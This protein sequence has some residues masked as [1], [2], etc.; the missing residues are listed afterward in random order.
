MPPADEWAALPGLLLTTDL[1]E[2]QLRTD[3]WREITRPLFETTPPV[4]QT[5]LEGSLRSMSVG[6]ILIGPTTFNAQQYRR[7]RRTILRSGLDS[8]LLQLFVEGA[9]VGDCDGQGV[10]ARPGDISVFD[11]ARTFSSDVT[12]G[13]TISLILPRARIEKAAG[14]RSLHGVVLAFENPVTRLLAD[15]IAGLSNA[16]PDLEGT[17]AL[18]MEDAVLDLLAAGISQRD[19]VSEAGAPPL[20]SIL[21]QRALEFIDANLF[22]PELGAA[23]LMARFRVSRA[24]LYRMFTADGGVAKVV[25]DRRLDAAYQE[26]IGRRAGPQRSLTEIAYG[27]GFSSSAQFA[28]AFRARFSIT[29]SEARHEAAFGFS[30]PQQ[31]DLQAHFAAYARRSFA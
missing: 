20:T 12:P 26:L 25:R 6:E 13:A 24:H 14:G 21:R 3:A 1:V 15:G 10:L 29:P 22:E 9:L 16:A 5:P 17:D 31:T 2:P 8:Y 28:R 18:A 27:L 11:L 19:L 4:K 30:D 7:D 23:R